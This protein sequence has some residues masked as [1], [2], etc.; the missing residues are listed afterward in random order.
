MKGFINVPSSINFR[1]CRH[2]GGNP[3]IMLS[4]NGLYV[5]KCPNDEAHY[6]TVPGIID[7]DDWNIHNTG[8]YE[9]DYN[10]R[11]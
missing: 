7:I 9:N 11:P 8:L 6:Q 10:V 4:D 2:C 5:V 1:L 3:V